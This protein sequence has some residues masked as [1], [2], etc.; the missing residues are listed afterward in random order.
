[1]TRTWIAALALAVASTTFGCA[2]K[3]E[4]PDEQQERDYASTQVEKDAAKGESTDEPKMTEMQQVDPNAEPVKATG[5]VATVNGEVIPAAD[6]NLEIERVIASGMP[7]GMLTQFKDQIVE[8]LV[9]RELIENAIDKS[10]VDVSKEEIDAKMLEVREEFAKASQ[11]LGEQASLEA[12]TKQLGISEQEL[13]D[14]LEQ[15]IAIEKVL[16]SRGLETPDEAKVKEFYEANQQ[17]FQRPEQIH[18]RHILVAV[19]N[20]DDQ[21][22]WDAAEKRAKIIRAEVTG[23]GADFA[24]IAKEKSDGPSAKTGGDLGFFGRK[25]MVPEFEQAAFALKKGEVSEP[26]KT[27]F[28]WHLIK[29][30]DKR[31]AGTVPFEDVNEE[32]ALQMKNQAVQQ[33]LVGF[34]EELRGS[35]TIEIHSDNIE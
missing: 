12:L 18:A 3:P 27:Q 17:Q 24:A 34:L 21:A 25:Q 14:S 11:Q 2:G 5:P 9:D 29:L 33:A 22:A 19:E 31:E 10:D 28:G 6:F 4:V 1:M 30:E 26:V 16:A 32:L 7:P 15:A 13:R 23:D 35:A 8:K 20:Q